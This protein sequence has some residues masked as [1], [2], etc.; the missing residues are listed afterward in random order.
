MSTI[1][2]AS[3]TANSQAAPDLEKRASS[4]DS[5]DGFVLA[6]KPG[7]DQD[8]ADM[9]RLGKKQQLNVGR[10]PISPHSARSALTVPPS[11]TSTPSP[12]SA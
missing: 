5:D 1:E 9:R 12:S 10:P 2:K 6:T 4:S 3:A 7:N 8:G 11:A